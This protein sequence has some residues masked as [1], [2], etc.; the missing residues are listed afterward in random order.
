MIYLAQNKGLGNALRLAVEEASYGYIARMDSDD[1]SLNDRFETEIKAFMEDEELD[2]VGGDISE[3]IGNEDNIVT[4]R[5]VPLKDSD[6]KKYMKIRSPLNHVSVM[7]KKNIVLKSGNYKD[8]FWNED[9]YLWIRMAING[10]KM[11]NTGKIA[12]NVR[13]GK[14]MY[15]RRGGIKYFRSEL[16]LQNFMLKNGM[17]N[18]F[19]YVSNVMQRFILQVILPSSIRG[20]VF[21]TLARQ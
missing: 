6:I 15:K 9:Y 18:I 3:F 12:V 11:A 16:F 14:D 17:I 21:R 4:K 20:L 7:Y 2:I 10:A 1:V 13:T 5:V 8:L 19:T